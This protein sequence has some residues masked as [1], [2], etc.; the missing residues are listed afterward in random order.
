MPITTPPRF[1]IVDKPIT[2]EEALEHRVAELEMIVDQ[3]LVVFKSPLPTTK[4]VFE[5]TNDPSA[6]F[7]AGMITHPIN[8]EYRTP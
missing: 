1:T 5:Q 8:L 7:E 3:L 2:R 6:P 4:R